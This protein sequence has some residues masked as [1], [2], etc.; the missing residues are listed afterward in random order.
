MK[1]LCIFDFDG[2]IADS[3]DVYRN[4]YVKAFEMEKLKFPL[5]AVE[6][7]RAQYDSAWENNF[8][9]FGIPAHKVPGILESLDGMI[10]YA[11]VQAFQGIGN[12]LKFCAER[13]ELGILSSTEAS[14]I[15][16]FLDQHGWLAYF[17]QISGGDG[18]SAKAERL[19]ALLRNFGV[20]PDAAVMIGD[21]SMDIRSG[22]MVGTATL[23]V[24]YGWYNAGRIAAENP[25]YIAHQPSEILQ[26][27]ER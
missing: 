26:I 24:T 4:L 20:A 16:Q 13:A 8:T 17:K 7:F 19:K 21:T 27:W 14:L 3:L 6:D 12:V 15:E 5:E 9:R 2:V 11:T 1:Q 18:K 25:T 22:K 10:S 23:G